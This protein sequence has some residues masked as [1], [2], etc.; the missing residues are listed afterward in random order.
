[1]IR[2]F[3]IDEKKNAEK[4]YKNGFA[5]NEYNNYE[6]YLVAKYLR[7]EFGYGDHKTKTQLLEFCH[8]HDENFNYILNRLSISKIIINS[9][10]EWK[11]KSHDIKITKSELDKIRNI[12]DFNAQKIILLFLVF[13]KRNNGYVYSNQWSDIIKISRLNVTH[14]KIHSC[15]N[16]AYEKEMVRDSNDNHFV[17]FIE[18]V[19]DATLKLSS[20]KDIWN[21]MKIYEEYCGGVI[22]YCENC[23]KELIKESNRHKYCDNCWKDK[24][25]GSWKIR[26]RKERS[27][28]T[29]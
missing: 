10:S 18:E 2:P 17:K 24:E 21:L 23:G 29:V 19:G 20:D 9:R 14:V 5:N 27:N 25:R 6:A 7:H 22:T 8:K 11:N 15:I 13:A 12:K 28:V 4:I 16:M 1:M 3:F 26:K